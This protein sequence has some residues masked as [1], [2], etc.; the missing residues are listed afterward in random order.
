MNVQPLITTLPDRRTTDLLG[1]PITHPDTTRFYTLKAY[2]KNNFVL[3]IRDNIWRVPNVNGNI[4]N[5][6][7]NYNDEKNIYFFCSIMFT[8]CYFGIC[9]LKSCPELISDDIY[10]FRVEWIRHSFVQFDICFYIGDNFKPVIKKDD[11][12]EISY[13]PG[14]GLLEILYRHE[15]VYIL[16]ILFI[17]SLIF[18]MNHKEIGISITK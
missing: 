16:F 13:T 6:I 7:D 10:E 18:Q 14:M 11:L 15:T 4:Q 17:N 1:L 9:T 12:E 5:L 8:K 2:N 3:S